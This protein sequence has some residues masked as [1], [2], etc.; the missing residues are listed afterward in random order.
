MNWRAI[1]AIVRKDLKVVSQNRGVVVPVIAVPLIIFGGLPWLAALAPHM[2]NI[3]GN[4]MDEIITLINNMPA[5]LQSELAPYTID[6]QTI[7]FFLVYLLAPMFLI[8]PLMVASTI[9]ADSFA[10]ERERRTLEALLYTPTTDRE[11]LV[12]KLLSSWLAANV[13]AL[14]GFILYTV[15]ANAA[16][17]GTLGR[18]F[19]PNLMWIVM[20]IW[21]M[22][23]AA[24]FGLA[25]MVLVSAR[26]QGFQDAYQ[27]GGMVVVPVLI[28]VFGQISGVMY[29]NVWV[30]LLL[31][32]VLWGVD[33]GL[34]AFGSRAF[35]R[36]QLIARL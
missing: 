34:I 23:S 36:G 28:L 20:V 17:W 11:L 24:G 8:I 18:I 2:I 7:V 13:V 10:G 4:N 3:A 1:F 31:G 26:A 25:T 33:I 5:G 22:P 9:A 32:L 30:V 19:F 29:F 27:M 21:V 16:A 12:G 6:Q 15:M 35:R 14:A